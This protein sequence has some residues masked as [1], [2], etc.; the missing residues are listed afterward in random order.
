MKYFTFFSYILVVTYFPVLLC[1]VFKLVFF[2]FMSST[3]ILFGECYESVCKNIRVRGSG[4]SPQFLLQVPWLNFWVMSECAHLWTQQEV[5]CTASERLCWW[6][7][8]LATNT[9]LKRKQISQDEKVVPYM[10]HCSY[11]KGKLQKNQ[12]VGTLS[13]VQVWKRLQLPQFTSSTRPFIYLY[14]ISSVKGWRAWV[15][16]LF[17]MFNPLNLFN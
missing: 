8:L 15:Q 4:L 12:I 14:F 17:D 2:G 13:G 3:L 11:V 5:G 10:L 1:S 9:K 6:R 7:F 16:Q